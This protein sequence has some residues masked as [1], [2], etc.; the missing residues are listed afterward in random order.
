LFARF[1]GIS[2]GKHGDLDRRDRGGHGTRGGKED[3]E[4]K[5]GREQKT[6]VQGLLK[7]WTQ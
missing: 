5:N 1:E 2:R 4:S 7:N 3:D 6:H